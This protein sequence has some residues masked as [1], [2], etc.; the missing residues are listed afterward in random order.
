MEKRPMMKVSTARPT[1]SVR[2]CNFRAL[3]MLAHV[4]G[5]VSQEEIHNRRK[6]ESCGT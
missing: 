4:Q 2:L 5:Y 1:S 6:Y 3:I